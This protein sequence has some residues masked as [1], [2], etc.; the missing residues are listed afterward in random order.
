[1]SLS[2][3]GGNVVC[4]VLKPDT[5]TKQPA[6]Y[7]ATLENMNKFDFAHARVVGTYDAA[8]LLWQIA[9]VDCTSYYP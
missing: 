5:G 3:Y 4:L 1:M 6:L 2:L 9:L 8:A 7:T